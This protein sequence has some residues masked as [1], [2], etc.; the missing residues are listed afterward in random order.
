MSLAFL[1]ATGWI[2][3]IR[4]YGRCDGQ[5]VGWWLA[6]VPVAPPRRPLRMWL[7][8]TTETQERSSIREENPRLHLL[9]QGLLVR[10]RQVPYQD[11]P[12]RWPCP[13][14]DLYATAG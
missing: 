1:P 9:L 7:G 2:G 13:S 5:K 4:F 6:S 10:R 3:A 11:L 12:R 8:K 14:S